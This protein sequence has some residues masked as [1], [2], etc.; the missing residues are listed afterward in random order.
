VPFEKKAGIQVIP[1]GGTLKRGFSIN[2][3]LLK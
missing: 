1:P 3:S 2:P